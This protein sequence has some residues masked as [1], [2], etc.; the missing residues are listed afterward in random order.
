MR[1]RNE[2]LSSSHSHVQTLETLAALPKRPYLH[3]SSEGGDGKILGCTISL[4][5]GTVSATESRVFRWASSWVLNLVKELREPFSPKHSSRHVI[6]AYVFKIMIYYDQLMPE[7]SGCTFMAGNSR[8]QETGVIYFC[9]LWCTT[10]HYLTATFCV[11]RSKVYLLAS[12][13]YPEPVT[14]QRFNRSNQAFYSAVLLITFAK[15]SGSGNAENKNNGLMPKMWLSCL[16]W[17]ESNSPHGKSVCLS[18]SL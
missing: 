3:N 5:M 11:S 7:T 8:F 13:S 6:A 17:S 14:W 12:G 1:I 4:N 10:K 9:H 16:L 15:K 18:R 2:Q